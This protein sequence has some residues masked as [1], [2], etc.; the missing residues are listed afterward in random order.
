MPSRRRTLLL[1]GIALM[2][3]LAGCQRSILPGGNMNRYVV[4]LTKVRRSRAEN[5]TA[6]LYV[7][8]LS[9]EEKLIIDRARRAEDDTYSKQWSELSDTE[10]EGFSELGQRIRDT[11]EIEVFIQIGDSYYQVGLQRGDIHY[12]KTDHST[13]RASSTSTQRSFD[14]PENR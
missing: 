5:S 6:L 9:S 14:S 13:E 1:G 10:K 7:E 8:N 11:S 3:G 2:A 12:A 4:K